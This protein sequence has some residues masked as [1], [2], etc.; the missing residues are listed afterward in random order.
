MHFNPIFS[1]ILLLTASLLV[2]FNALFLTKMD[3]WPIDL[4]YFLPLFSLTIILDFMIYTTNC[5]TFNGGDHRVFCT[6]PLSRFDVIFL[7]VK[8]YYKRWEFVVFIASIL[9]YTVYFY[10]LNNSKILPVFFVIVFFSLQIIYLV[11]I[12]F[13]TKNLFNYKNLDSDIKNFSSILITAIILIYSF[14]GS[15]KTIEF[16]FYINPLSCGFLCYLLG[17][18]YAI[19]S[20]CLIVMTIFIFCLFAKKY[21][22][23][24][25]SLP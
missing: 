13:L 1:R 17:Q 11:G 4:F 18:N 6:F 23:W 9:F 3:T 20:F 15:S 16:I 22:E 2:V 21:I 10:I 25:L 24:P 19:I 14:S 12:L 5:T 7:E 8:Y